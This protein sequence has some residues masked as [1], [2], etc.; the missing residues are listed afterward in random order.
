MIFRIILLCTTL[1]LLHWSHPSLG[2]AQDTWSFSLSGFGGRTIIGSTNLDIRDSTA[3]AIDG[4]LENALLNNSLSFGGKATAWWVTPSKRLPDVGFEVDITSFEMTLPAQQVNGLG[5]SN[6]FPAFLFVSFL[7]PID[8]QSQTFALNFVGRYPIGI[9]GDLPNGRWYPYVGIGGGVSRTKASFAGE[10]TTDLA[11]LLQGVI[12]VNLFL[13]KHVS[14]F[15]EY[16]RTHASHT[17]GFSSIQTN[18]DLTL[19]VNHLVAGV[20]VH[21]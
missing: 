12:G 15:T 8:F 6:G 11:P 19:S 17:F 5:T 7:A 10:S 14:L 13:T 1:L 3:P 4:E 20:G 2:L 21:F 18:V 9:T 16:K